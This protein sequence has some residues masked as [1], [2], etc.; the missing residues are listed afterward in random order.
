[1]RLYL[2]QAHST[3]CR[4]KDHF[5]QYPS[6]PHLHRFDC[7]R[8]F[9]FIRPNGLYLRS[10]RWRYTFKTITSTIILPFLFWWT[11]LVQQ[12]SGCF[13]VIFSFFSCFSL[14]AAF[15]WFFGIIYDDNFNHSSSKSR[16]SNFGHLRSDTYVTSGDCNS[17][18]R[19]RADL[20]TYFELVL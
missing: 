5:Y 12:F 7:F 10:Y 9:D 13:I 6:L 8:F 11:I 2:S 15:S 14:L 17:L 4:T 3:L 19:T 16:S 1:M 20:N 18:I